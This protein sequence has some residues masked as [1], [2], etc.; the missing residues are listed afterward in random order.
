MIEISDVEKI[1]GTVIHPEYDKSVM[2]LSLVQNLAVTEQKISFRLVWH[3]ADPLAGSLKEACS[4]ALKA[5]F[6]GVEVSIL[7]L[8]DKKN[9]TAKKGLKNIDTEGL[10]DVANIIAIASGKGGVG[11]STVAVNLGVAL[12]KLGYKVGLLDADVYGPSIPK[13]TATENEMPQ[14]ADNKIVPIEKFGIKWISIGYFAKPEQ[15]LIWRGPMACGALKQLTYEV[16]WGEL[17]YLLIDLPPGTGDIHISMIQETPLTG[18]IIVT[19][20]QSVAL[21]DVEKG[22]NMFRNKDVRVSI[23]G[24]VENMSWFTPAELPG[25]KYFIFG[26]G[27]GEKMAEKYGVPLL[28]QIPIVQSVMEGG[29]VGSPAAASD[30]MVQE[31]FLNLARKVAKG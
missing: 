20:P 24:I 15:A 2:E 29:E 5:A 7:E 25:N 18:A 13:M 9:V 22:I 11:K 6:P 14:M 12:S 30:P 1:L 16:Q 8:I 21:A 4:K 17:D 10:K 31:A 28:A 23:L 3:R 27:G 19:T 26:K